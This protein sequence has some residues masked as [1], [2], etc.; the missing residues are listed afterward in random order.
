CDDNN[1]ITADS[2]NYETQECE[3]MIDL[4]I[5]PEPFVVNGVYD[6]SN[7]FVFGKCGAKE[8]SA[9]MDVIDKMFLEESTTSTAGTVSQVIGYDILAEPEKRHN[10]NLI[11]VG[12]PC[13]NYLVKDIFGIG[14][15]DWIDEFKKDE[16]FIILTKNGEDKVALLVA[17]YT[18]DDTVATAEVLANYED[19]DLTG[20]NFLLKE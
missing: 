3:N 12:G 2:F 7:A 8:Q 11:F 17:G 18:S 16:S 20:T 4:K 9:G 13:C 6:S 15:L 10:Y 5:F 1:K 14:C 19:Y